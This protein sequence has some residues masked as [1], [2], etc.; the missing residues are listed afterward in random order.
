MSTYSTSPLYNL[1]NIQLTVTTN[2][3]KF[4]FPDYPQLRDAKIQAISLYSEI[5][6]MTKDINNVNLL[7]I[8]DSG[9]AYLTL[10]SGN[11]EDIQNL[12][13][14]K[15]AN[16]SQTQK[17]SNDGLFQLDNLIVD[18]SKSFIQFASGYAPTTV[19]PY[20]FQFGIYYTK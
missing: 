6:G 2:T 17:G 19:L 1:L 20:S 8:A 14:Y 3:G 12:P 13:L 5:S 10:Y 18:F 15:L 7:N 11:K 16:I 4:Y 9:Y